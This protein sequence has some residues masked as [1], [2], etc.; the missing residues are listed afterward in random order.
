MS[1]FTD[2]GKQFLK[3]SEKLVEKTEEYTKIAKLTLEIKKIESTIDKIH[4]EVGKLVIESIREGKVTL[5]LENEY[6][7]GT[8]GKIQEYRE[9]IESKKKEI[10]DIKN[11]PASAG[12]VSG[13]STDHSI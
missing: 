11:P 3:Y 9:L 7:K 13:H 4:H 8:A 10:F 1:F 12:S 2:A 5:D 6:F